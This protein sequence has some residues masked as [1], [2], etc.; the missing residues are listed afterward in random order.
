M[1]LLIIIIVNFVNVVEY[2][3]F[4]GE[5]EMLNIGNY[6][7]FEDRSKCFLIIRLFIFVF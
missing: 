7:V 1:L 6:V 4:F 2:L 5:F 3:F